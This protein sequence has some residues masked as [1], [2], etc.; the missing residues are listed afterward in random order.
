MFVYEGSHFSSLCS[1]IKTPLLFRVYEDSLPPYDVFLSSAR[2]VIRA[3]SLLHNED[4]FLLL[5]YEDSLCRSFVKSS[6]PSPCAQTSFHLFVY[7]DSRLRILPSLCSSMN[8]SFHC[9]LSICSS[10]KTLFLGSYMKISSLCSSK[11]FPLQLDYENPL[12]PLVYE[13]SL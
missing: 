11:N 1:S 4:P 12:P 2:T 10:M 5:V 6:F 13:D 7:E 3:E 9:S 8:L